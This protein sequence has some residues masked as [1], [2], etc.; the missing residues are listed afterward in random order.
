MA[1][2]E[3]L[4]RLF[5]KNRPQTPS[6][7]RKKRPPRHLKRRKPTNAYSDDTKLES[8]PTLVDQTPAPSAAID[9]ATEQSAV[10]LV[11]YLDDHNQPLSDPEWVRG[12]IGAAVHFKPKEFEDYLLY[13]IIGFTTVFKTPCRIMTWQFMKRMGHPV[14]MYPIDYDTGELVSPPVFTSGPVNKGFVLA[15][16]EADQYHLVKA[17]RPLSGHFTDEVQVIYV[18]LRRNSWWAVQR[19]NHYIKLTHDVTILDMPD[20]QSQHYEFPKDSIW[21]AF[22]RV[23]TAHGKTW[24][25]LG[26]PQWVPGHLAVQS[27]RPVPASLPKPT[28]PEYQ[29]LSAHGRI[30]FI[31]DQAVHTYTAPNGV[32]KGELNDQAEIIV[33]G[34]LTDANR[35]EWY[36]LAD[37]TAIQ[38]YYVTLNHND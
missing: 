37:G 28:T 12:T 11:L 32:F 2:F 8:R 24:Y 7:R 16:P 20:G 21:R 23:N 34:T 1:F 19:V 31:P 9:T 26:G 29:P 27:D 33:T 4:R 14:I 15:Q 38:S 13:H 30:N 35:V 18:L 6:P 10:L 5:P 25:N 17:S 22:I 36:Q 3:R